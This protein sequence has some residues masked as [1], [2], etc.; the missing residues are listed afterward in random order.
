[1]QQEQIPNPQ[2]PKSK[3][4]IIIVGIISALICLCVGAIVAF[5]IQT[6]LREKQYVGKP[7]PI[8]DQ[9]YVELRTAALNRKPS[10][11]GLD[12]DPNNNQPYGIIMDWNVG[13]ATSTLVSFATGD[14][15]LYYST[16]GG[17]IGGI[18]IE[19]VNSASI[20]FV[21]TADGFVDQLKTVTTFPMPP[22]G[23]IRFYIT[24]G[25]S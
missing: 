11:L 13:Q 14:T 20:Q 12:V 23:Y 10:E 3:I 5:R 25:A 1:M 21:T 22:V 7:T 15:S 4:W 16:G 19:K 17:W 8:P 24:F 6:E 9:V 2:K 18:T